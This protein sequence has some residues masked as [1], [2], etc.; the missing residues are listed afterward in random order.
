MKRDLST[1]NT[2]PL[3]LGQTAEQ[4]KI[5]S[6]PEYLTASKPVPPPA[7]TIDDFALRF[8]DL[9]SGD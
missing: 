9:K 3:P 8:S 5:A 7:K 2:L 6:L 4:Q 1:G